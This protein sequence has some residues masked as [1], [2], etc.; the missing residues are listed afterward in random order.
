M[1]S[2]HAHNAATTTQLLSVFLSFYNKLSSHSFVFT[3]ILL[4][5]ASNLKLVGA[6]LQIDKLIP[7]PTPMYWITVNRYVFK[8]SGFREWEIQTRTG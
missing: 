4:C 1:I 6:E 5:I 2:K 3:A 7:E 8:I